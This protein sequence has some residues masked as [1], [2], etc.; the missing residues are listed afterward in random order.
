MHAL[1][2]VRIRI[3]DAMTSGVLSIVLAAFAGGMMET[4]VVAGDVFSSE[5]YI[6][7]LSLAFLPLILTLVGWA[8]AVFRAGPFGF[9]G[10][11]L[12]WTGASSLFTDPAA[13]DLGS[14]A[15]GAVIVVFGAFVWSWKPVLR[16]L[17]E[18]RTRRPPPVRPR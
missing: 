16:Y 4:G 12:E 6:L 5:T 14:I 1:D 11:L 8:V 3:A 9:F 18:S 15:F 7:L 2:R 13:A 17:F 10:F